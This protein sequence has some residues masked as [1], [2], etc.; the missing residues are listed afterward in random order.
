MSQTINI[1]LT[2]QAR[3]AIRKLDAQPRASLAPIRDAIN[4]QNELTVGHIIQHR[5]T[6]KGPFPPSLG[7]LGVRSSRLRRSLRPSKARIVDG[8]IVS[9]IGTNVKYAAIHEFGGQTKPHT[10]KPRRKQALYFA[11]GGKMVTVGQVNHPG[12]KIPRRRP[13]FLG[14]RDRQR[15]YGSAISAA[16]T[17]SLI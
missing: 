14:I 11:F 7:K 15:F 5:M 10:I 17:K 9:A 1:T 8:G 4:L 2:P 16:I 13:I 12:S 6:G 3:A